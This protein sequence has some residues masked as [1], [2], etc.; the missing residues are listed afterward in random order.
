MCVAFLC[1]LCSV[2]N[3]PYVAGVYES[4]QVCTSAYVVARHVTV[5]H[6]SIRGR[7]YL[8]LLT[9]PYLLLDVALG[10][11]ILDSKWCV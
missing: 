6:D 5:L 2:A 11:Y 9:A 7:L 1:S 10:D 3:A 8:V 4:V